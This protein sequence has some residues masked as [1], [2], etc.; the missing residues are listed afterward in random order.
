MFILDRPGVKPASQP[1]SHMCSHNSYGVEHP[2]V[3][4]LGKS[5]L[6][7]ENTLTACLSSK[8]HDPTADFYC[9]PPPSPRPFVI[10]YVCAPLICNHQS[11]QSCSRLVLHPHPSFTS[12]TREQDRFNNFFQ[13]AASYSNHEQPQCL[14]GSAVA[15]TSFLHQR[16]ELNGTVRTTHRA[17]S[18]ET[19]LSTRI[20]EPESPVSYLRN[21]SRVFMK[22][23]IPAVGGIGFATEVLR[24]SIFDLTILIVSKTVEA[25]VWL[26]SLTRASMAATRSW[27]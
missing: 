22:S 3:I 10:L 11:M 6:R 26:R 17:P 24:S 25:V 7:A 27:L 19:A 12:V 21:R 20:L 9:P 4:A 2:G 16:S 13:L 1:V 14:T 8:R 18:E 23:S 15:A 5:I